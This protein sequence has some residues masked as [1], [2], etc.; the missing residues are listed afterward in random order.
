MKRYHFASN[1]SDLAR[2]VDPGPRKRRSSIVENADSK[3]LTMRSLAS[4]LR[5]LE[6]RLIP[7]DTVP[8]EI[9]IRCV[10]SDGMTVGI[11]TLTADGLK[12]REPA[13]SS[14][15]GRER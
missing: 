6:S 10:D 9:V 1:G 2:Q 5:R 15:P 14:S 13:N 11:Y 3:K 8:S 12:P 7:P 4:R